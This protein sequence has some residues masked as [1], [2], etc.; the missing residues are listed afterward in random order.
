M[1]A[2]SLSLPLMRTPC[3]LQNNVLKP[4]ACTEISLRRPMPT[5]CEQ[6]P[7]VTSNMSTPLSNQTLLERMGLGNQM[8]MA[9][10][11]LLLETSSSLTQALVSPSNSDMSSTVVTSSKPQMMRG[12]TEGTTL[13]IGINQVVVCHGRT[14]TKEPFQLQQKPTYCRTPTSPISSKHSRTSNPNKI[15]QTFPPSSGEMYSQIDTLISKH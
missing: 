7:K 12:M 13:G 2:A 9:R 3:S 14:L 6:L 11:G 15:I 1:P 10:L 5:R 8:L 4:I